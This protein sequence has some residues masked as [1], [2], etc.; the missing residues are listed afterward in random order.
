M[1]KTRF[2]EEKIITGLGF[3]AILIIVSTFLIQLADSKINDF[4]QEL[5][6]R[7]RKN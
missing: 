7:P 2:T 4:N 1:K 5:S 3:L 6:I